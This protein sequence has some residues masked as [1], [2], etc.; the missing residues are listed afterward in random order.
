M[1]FDKRF[2][3][4]SCICCQDIFIGVARPAALAQA[5]ARWPYV[6]TVKTSAGNAFEDLRLGYQ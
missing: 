6:L 5:R 1:Q 4:P 2:A 3:S